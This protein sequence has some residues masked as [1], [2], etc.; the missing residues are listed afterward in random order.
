MD[1][2]PDLGALG[3]QDLKDPIQELTKQEPE[4]AYQRRILHGKID[5]LRAEHVHRLRRQRA[6][7]AAV[8]LDGVT[9]S[10][11]LA[12]LVRRRDGVYIDDLGSLNGTY[13]S[14]RRIESHKLQDGDELQV[15]KYKLTFLG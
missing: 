1:T 12:L 13:V 6:E 5:S 3:D 7:A 4:V 8:V 2:F 9:V 11:N 14:R 10:R 15:G